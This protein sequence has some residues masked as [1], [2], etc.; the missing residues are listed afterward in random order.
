MIK[1]ISGVV[2][3]G[4]ENRRFKGRFKPD[5]VIDGR[6]IFDRI[7]NIIDKIFGEIIIVTNNPEKFK[8]YTNFN[9]VSDIYKNKGPLGGIHA[10]MVSSS[11]EAVFVFAGDMP[12]LKKSLIINQIDAFIKKKCDALVP[13][14]NNYPEPLHSIYSN[15]LLADLEKYLSAAPDHSVQEFLE[16]IDTNYLTLPV[17]KLTLKAFKN[18]NSPSDML[19]L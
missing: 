3:A 18:I 2:L 11:A 13:V 14:L 7:I 5:I 15:S 6:T 19:D 12:F 10:A 1:N 4:G 8:K 16:I 9:I 17:D